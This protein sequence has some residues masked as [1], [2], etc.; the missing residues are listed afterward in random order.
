MFSSVFRHDRLEK[1][2]GLKN[3]LS[4]LCG[5]GSRIRNFLTLDL[6][7]KKIPQHWSSTAETTD[8]STRSY[9]CIFSLFQS[10]C[11]L[12]RRGPPPPLSWVCSACSDRCCPTAVVCPWRRPRAAQVALRRRKSFFSWIFRVRGRAW[13]L[14]YHNDT[15]PYMASLHII[16]CLRNTY[17]PKNSWFQLFSKK[18]L[19]ICTLILQIKVSF[20]ILCF[21]LSYWKV[22]YNLF[23]RLLNI[24]YR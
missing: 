16:S 9:I 24:S 6:G 21:S 13:S 2:F 20:L 8:S 11:S 23:V 15:V 1:I 5:S 4:L 22:V 17:V 18:A 14:T 7:W 3:A 10:S 19:A 12:R